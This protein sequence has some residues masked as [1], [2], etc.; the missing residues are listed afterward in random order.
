LEHLIAKHGLQDRVTLDL[1][2]L[3]RERLASYVNGALACAYLPV[4]EDSVGYVTMEAFYASKA[5]LCCKDSGGL[6]DLV[7]HGKNGLVV[8]PDPGSL[9]EAMS[10]FA[11]NTS[12][13]RRMGT[14]AHET[15]RHLA[16]N[17]EST[18]ERLLS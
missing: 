9:A 12:K 4:E 2:F 17:W 16:P 3:P 10:T 11:S 13:T 15:I 6:L 18:I 5:V 7:R 8:E 1:G 14:N